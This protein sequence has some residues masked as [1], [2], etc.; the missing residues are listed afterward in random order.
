MFNDLLKKWFGDKEQFQVVLV[1]EPEPEPQ[2]VEEIIQIPEIPQA[3][4][5]PLDEACFRH[6]YKRMKKHY[7][8]GLSRA[9]YDRWTKMIQDSDPGIVRLRFHQKRES[10]MFVTQHG[11]DDI[12]LVYR[13]GLI[14]TVLPIGK[15]RGVIA[16]SKAYAEFLRKPF[17]QAP[18]PPP[19]IKPEPVFAELL[20]VKPVNP[21]P[22]K[23]G[24]G[25]AKNAGWGKLD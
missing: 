14:R 5:L 19:V 18:K 17:K 15:F 12:V 13:D 6:T 11:M 2:P 21:T 7:A 25:K 10:D 20:R 24:K 1:E 8:L 9:T 3:Y 23:K 16:S 4:D 22:L